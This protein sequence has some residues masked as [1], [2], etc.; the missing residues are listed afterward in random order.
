ME[1]LAGCEAGCKTRH[2]AVQADPCVFRKIVKGVVVLSLTVHVDNMAVAG[3]RV[4]VDKLL[5]KL[6]EDFTTV[7]LG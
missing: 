7:D 6:N 4:E 5:V 3:P 1:Q 2:G